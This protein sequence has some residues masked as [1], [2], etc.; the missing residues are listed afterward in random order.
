VLFAIAMV[1]FGASGSAI[2]RPKTGVAAMENVPA[3]DASWPQFRDHADHSGHNL[4]E[5]ELSPATVP[6]L[7]DRWTYQADGSVG[8]SPAIAHG[9]V[10][11][12][13]SLHLFALDASTGAVVWSY[14]VDRGLVDASPA[15]D[16]G[17]VFATS[18]D[19]L[20]ALDAA[21]GELRWSRSFRIPI[22]SNPAV[23]GAMLYFASE[24]TVFAVHPDSGLVKWSRPLTRD[25][26]HSTPAVAGGRVYVSAGGRRGV[27]A[28]DAA[29]GTVDWSAALPMSSGSSPAVVNGMVY[30][31][32]TDAQVY[33]LDASTGAVR[34]TF[35]TGGFVRS[36]P[37]VA[38]GTVFV[39]SDDGYL[40]ALKA[41]NGAER[42]AYPTSNA[43]RSA[44]AVANGV[45]YF[46][47]ADGIHALDAKT[48]ESLWSQALQRAAVSPAV[49]NGMVFVGSR[50]ASIH[51]FGLP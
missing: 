32:D 44:P 28:I 38:D 23:S 35:K 11:I 40:Y 12:A 21:T 5:T 22:D 9:L 17:L 51:A 8:S 4:T 39:G 26:I 37:A 3:D 42:W 18:Q 47:S 10:Y 14:P 41:S 29:T 46:G 48:G 16:G 36:S 34:W 7:V 25:D 2:A 31:G 43:L 13:S 19:S 27:V 15:V 30:V 45:V 49:V 6:G 50:D 24:E 20:F 1:A 33:A